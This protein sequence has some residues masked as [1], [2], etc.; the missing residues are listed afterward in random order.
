MTFESVP[1]HQRTRDHVSLGGNGGARGARMIG[2]VVVAIA[3]VSVFWWIS[4]S[5]HTSEITV[6]T[7]V[8]RVEV[9]VFAGNV[10]IIGGTSGRVH[11]AAAI[12]DGWVRSA[13][14]THSVDGDTLRIDGDCRGHDLIPAFGCRTDVTLTVPAG[15]DVV[16]MS[17]GGTVEAR[18]LHGAAQLTSD[19]GDVVVAGH[20]GRL[21]AHSD[22]GDVLVTGLRAEDARITSSAG[23][24]RV[25]TLTPPRSLDAES[26][27]GSVSV[28][29]PAGTAY[30]VEAKSRTQAPDVSAR[31]SHASPHKVRAFSSA[32]PVD[33][34]G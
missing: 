9:D 24:V 12:D 4:R 25:E 30:D 8:S 23:A 15:V 13:R 29:L 7:D 5:S 11:V 14:V 32:G 20:T 18:G 3:A 10:E 22:A 6:D 31:T 16:A 19:A 33:V 27:A 34:T 28:D 2:V 21:Q 26:S 1:S 17:A